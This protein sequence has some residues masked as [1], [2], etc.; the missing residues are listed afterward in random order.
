MNDE[1]QE[2]QSQTPHDPYAQL[3]TM[4]EAAAVVLVL[5][6]AIVLLFRRSGEVSF[7]K[8]MVPFAG[9]ICTLALLSVLYKENAIYRLFEH[10]FIGLGAGYGVVLV[11]TDVLEPEWWTPLK[12]GG[13]YWLFPMFLAGL[14]YTVYSKKYAWMS[15]LLVGFIFG[16]AAGQAFQGFAAQV[17]PQVAKSF[18]PLWGEGVTFKMFFDN[19]V[20]VL[21]LA[22]VLF[23]FF[24]S[25]RQDKPAVRGA[26][27]TGRWL[28]MVAFGA[29]FG[30]TVMGRFSLFIGRVQFLLYEWLGQ[31]K[32]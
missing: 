4:L 32:Y 17:L 24:F 29:V 30:S 7:A 3:R 9:A 21:T 11:W 13:W 23:Y 28:M 10:I 25:F 31:Q 22:C 20:F 19:F 18:K 8:A 16:L 6:V 14:Y 26:A 27:T 1:L 5:L 12:A 15:R 2:Q